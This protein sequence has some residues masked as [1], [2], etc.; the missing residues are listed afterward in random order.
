[1][2]YFVDKVLSLEETKSGDYRAIYNEGTI[3][4]LIK[5]EKGN[6]FFA[7]KK[8]SSNIAA[9]SSKLGMLM[10]LLKLIPS[11]LLILTRIAR[12]VSLA[13]DPEVK[14]AVVEVSKDRYAGKKVY[15]NVIVGS[16]VKKQKIVLQCFCPEEKAITVYLKIGDEQTENELVTETA[17]LTNPINTKVFNSP[18]LCYSSTREVGNKYNIQGTNEFIGDTVPPVITADIVDIYKAICLSHSKMVDN[19]GESLYFSHGDFVPWNIKMTDRGYTLFD[20][21]YCCFRFYGFDLIHFAWQVENKLKK[22]DIHQALCSAIADCKKW[23][24]Q[25]CNYDYEEL[26]RKYFEELHKQFGDVL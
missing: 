20:W 21:E 10:K 18:K 25:L 12:R 5:I 8:L 13:I 22:K 26:E 3:R 14:R 9:Y 2:G 4:Y 23:Y 1:M 17:Y 15:F 11:N 19:R 7:K 16:Y 6:S 24:E